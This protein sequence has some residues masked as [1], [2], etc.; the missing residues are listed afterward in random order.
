MIIYEKGKTKF[1]YI[2]MQF[3]ASVIKYKVLLK[4]IKIFKIF[5]NK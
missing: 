4:E 1:G 2:G 5:K 3:I